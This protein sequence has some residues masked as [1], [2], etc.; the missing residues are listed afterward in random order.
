MAINSFGCSSAAITVPAT[1]VALVAVLLPTGQGSAMRIVNEGPNVVFV[2]IGASSV[3]ATLPTTGTGTV[4]CTPV[5][6][7]ED[8][9]LA[10]NPYTDLY[11][12][13]ICRA[14]GTATLTVAIGEGS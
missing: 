7:N 12:S 4:T 9:I 5:L 2:A 1:A 8:L 13:T 10:R 11:I 3:L 14:A 6:V